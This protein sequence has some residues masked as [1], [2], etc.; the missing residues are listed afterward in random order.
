MDFL[1]KSLYEQVLNFTRRAHLHRSRSPPIFGVGW[2]T[3]ASNCWGA[4]VDT[5]TDRFGQ[6]WV[7]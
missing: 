5:R 3:D 2:A 7:V 1:Y 4:G 6:V